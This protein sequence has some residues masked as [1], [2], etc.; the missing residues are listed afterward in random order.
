MKNP[1]ISKWKTVLLVLLIVFMTFAAGTGQGQTV[2]YDAMS[3]TEL[4]NKIA[5]LG[6]GLGSYIVGRELTPEQQATAEKDS[7]YKSYPGTVKFK[8]KDIFVIADQETKVVIALYVRNKQATQDDFKA[9]IGELMMRFGEPTAEAHGK[10]IY[11][12]YAADGLITEELYRTVKDKGLLETLGVLATVKFSSSQSVDE[13]SATAKEE[14]DEAEKSIASSDN[15]V[16]I[17]SDVLSK[18]YMGN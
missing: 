15:Y 5:T 17:Q 2:D 11:W 1:I 12:N 3:R 18:K 4:Q 7:A 9:M 10:T 8:D 6:L 14:K 16:M 13:L